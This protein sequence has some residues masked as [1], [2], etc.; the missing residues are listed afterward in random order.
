MND[1]SEISDMV[2]IL[3]E[4]LIT[5]FESFSLIWY[6]CKMNGYEP[7]L[8]GHRKNYISASLILAFIS[9]FLYELVGYEGIWAF[10]YVAYYFIFSLTVTK[11]T[12]S[13]CLF[14]A[15]TAELILICINALV[16][17]AVAL[18]WNIVPEELFA[19]HG[20]FKLLFLIMVQSVHIGVFI[21]F[22]RWFGK[23]EKRLG[24]GQWILTVLMLVLSFVII[25]MIQLAVNNTI[26]SDESKIYLMTA[27]TA[28]IVTDIVT[29]M[30]F[31]ALNKSNAEKA[32]LKLLQEQEKYRIKY[33]ENVRE[34][35]HEIRRIRHDMK[36]SFAVISA[37]CSENNNEKAFEYANS[38]ADKLEKMCRIIDV[39]NDFANAIINSKISLAGEKGIKVI[40]HC[41][42]LS[43]PIDDE[44]IC[45]LIGNMF[46]NAIEAA[47]KCDPEKRYIEL[48][49]RC[50][51]DRMNLKISNSIC[52]PVLET[53][54][55]SD[56]SKA[57]KKS[58]GFGVQ[59]INSIADKYGGNVH[60]FEE[61]AYLC[62]NVVLFSQEKC[63]T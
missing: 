62:C 20:L 29:L 45:S 14:S 10:I 38:C 36:Q 25:A 57:N 24:A 50:D 46:D 8:A 7:F 21:L 63:Q 53:G 28:V 61:G 1:G 5:V 30:I 31:D 9:V 27:E 16:T 32:E 3:S 48:S 35:Y 39:E 44:D 15:V 17:N 59:T 12:W 52:E 55:L 11:S 51:K 18:V 6:I 22:I 58:H 13:R 42:T 37:F 41:T 40:C 34:Q 19:A 49:L 23:S 54:K 33:A 60:Y 2:W 56:T 26:L 43:F 4:N 47:E